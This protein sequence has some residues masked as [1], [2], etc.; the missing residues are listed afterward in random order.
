MIAQ[1]WGGK[2]GKGERAVANFDEDSITMAVEAGRQCL[3][4][5]DKSF[6]SGLFF[7]SS[8]PPYK[9]K[10]SASIIAAALDLRE[11]IFTADITDSLRSGTIALKAALDMVKSGSARSALVTAADCRLA[12]PNS[13]IEP[14]FGD[15]AAAFLVGEDKVAV[16]VEG[17]YYLA[18]EF[19]DF[20]RLENDK[21]VRTWEDRFMRE[22]G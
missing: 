21:S 18:S 4:G 19:L 12:A 22:E 11:D 2:G 16:E 10:Q 7:A 6:V 20:W 9:E 15:G 13:S 5:M 8:T 17:S 1:V 14:F 3:K